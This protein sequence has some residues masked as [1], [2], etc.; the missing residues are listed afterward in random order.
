MNFEGPLPLDWRYYIAI[1][2]NIYYNYD[3][4]IFINELG[5]ERLWVQLPII[6]IINL[7]LACGR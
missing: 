3:F 1:M 5:G 7:V 6:K 4:K 2:V